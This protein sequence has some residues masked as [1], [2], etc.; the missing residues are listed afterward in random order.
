MDHAEICRR[1]EVAL[2]KDYDE[3]TRHDIAFHMTDWL[4]DLRALLRIY[5]DPVSA[6]DELI[7]STLMTFLVHAPAHIAAAAKLFT[8]SPVEDLFGVGA[9]EE[10]S[11][12]E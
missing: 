9:V 10:R 3:A 5:Q 6:T 8:G 1:I 2:E 11:R 7:A 12:P 4:P